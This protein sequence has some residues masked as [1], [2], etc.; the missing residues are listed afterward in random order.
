ME[1]ALVLLPA[2]D[3]KG[4]DVNYHAQDR[5][6]QDYLLPHFVWTF[7]LKVFQKQPAAFLPLLSLCK[8]QKRP[9]LDLTFD[10][11]CLGLFRSFVCALLLQ[12]KAKVFVVFFRHNWD[13]K[14]P[15]AL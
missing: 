14:F 13:P 4:H 11:S 9:R 12:R 6:G 8:G 15:Q 7:S 5:K 2:D 3:N 10:S 1:H